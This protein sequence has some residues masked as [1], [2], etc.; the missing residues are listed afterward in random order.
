M[1]HSTRRLEKRNMDMNLDSV[2][3]LPDQTD[4]TSGA[5]RG[6]C[7][8]PVRLNALNIAAGCGL[9]TGLPF[10]GFA[11]LVLFHF[12]ARGSFLLDSGLLAFLTWHN[13]MSLTR[14]DSFSSGSFFATHMSPLFLLT[15]ALS[16][17]VPCSMPQFFA[18]FI[19][20]SH[21]LPALALFWLL[22]EG[23][24][25]RRGAA[26]RPGLPRLR[27]HSAGWQSRSPGI[28]ISRL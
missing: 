26:R 17:I 19:G 1:N 14:P 20:F 4:R 8:L 22:V 3:E 28:P 5:A 27:S 21:A 9:A 6:R 18:G 16:R 12:Y 23:Y 15:G 25:L 11:R 24:G 13:D 10:V 2:I 7:L